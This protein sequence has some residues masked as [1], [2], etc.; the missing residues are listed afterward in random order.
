MQLRQLDLPLR[1]TLQ[2]CC[3]CQYLLYWTN[4]QTFGKYESFAHTN[5]ETLVPGFKMAYMLLIKNK[6]CSHCGVFICQG[7]VASLL[8][9][10]LEA[11]P[12]VIHIHM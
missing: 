11:G 1:I 6:S 5:I 8:P 2:L 9:L 3:G 4:S 7:G 10:Y 12:V